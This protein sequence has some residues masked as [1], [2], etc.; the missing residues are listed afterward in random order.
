MRNFFFFT[1]FVLI[2]SSC[3]SN[4]KIALL[5]RDDLKI[6]NLPLDTT[7]RTYNLYTFDY[8]I[9]SNDIISV[10]FE[11]LTPKEFDFFS[12]GASNAMAG[13]LGLQ[14]ALLIGELVDEKG[15]IPFPV[16]GKIKVSG[17]TVFQI[18]ELIQGIASKYIESPVVK[19]RLLNYRTTV[20]GEVNHQG[21]ILLN[22]NRVNI[23]EVIGLAGGFSELADRANVKLIRQVGSKTEVQYINL[24]DENLMVSR[25]FY[26]NQN[27]ILIVRPLRQ[28]PFR[29]YFANNLSLIVSSISL[30]LLVANLYK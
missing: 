12:I 30:V 21:T 26:V 2:L 15:E 17:L 23:L 1:L 13:G 10:R 22:N 14:N 4:K 20:L 6:R 29:N 18:Q 25:Y 16:V 3:V 11:S 9:Q 27:D 5:Q 8:R 28:K 24:L 19:V 7:V